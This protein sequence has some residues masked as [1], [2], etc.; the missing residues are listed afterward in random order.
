MPGDVFVTVGTTSFD[1][2]IAAVDCEEFVSWLVS[3]KYTS[4]TLQVNFH[5]PPHPRHPK[6]SRLHARSLSQVGRHGYSIRTLEERAR[7]VFWTRTPH[8]SDLS[9]LCLRMA[10]PLPSACKQRRVAY[11][12]YDL[13]PNLIDDL[14]AAA[15][16]ISHAGTPK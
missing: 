2:L 10:L 8:T 3:E 9:H 13:K 7:C 6:I 11:Q 1:N 4:L 5:P 14:A 12:C 16:V 15:L